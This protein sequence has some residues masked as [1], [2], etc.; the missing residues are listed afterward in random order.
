MTTKRPLLRTAARGSFQACFKFFCKGFAFDREAQWW[1]QWPYC[2]YLV[3]H[4]NAILY[5]K[6]DGM[7]DTANANFVQVRSVPSV[8]V[9]GVQFVDDGGNHLYGL[10]CRDFSCARQD[11]TLFKLFCDNFAFCIG[12]V[13]DGKANEVRKRRVNHPV[14]LNPMS[15]KKNVRS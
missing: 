8:F 4:I 10:A 12:C 2:P 1:H 11:T 13:R 6:I 14:I 15:S 9:L 5:G 7:C 3:N